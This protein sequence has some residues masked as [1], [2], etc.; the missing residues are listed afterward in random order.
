MDLGEKEDV[1]KDICWANTPP[2]PIPGMYYI[3][4]QIR[5]DFTTFDG[6]LEKMMP[7]RVYT[8]LFDAL[9][10]DFMRIVMESEEGGKEMGEGTRRSDRECEESVG[11]QERR[12]EL[13]RR[14]RVKRDMSSI[15]DYQRYI[16]E[17]F[18]DVE[19]IAHPSNKDAK[20]EAVFDLFPDTSVSHVLVQ[21]ECSGMEAGMDLEIS[22]DRGS[23]LF[24]RI[25]MPN[26]DVAVCLPQRIENFMSFQIR[27]GNAYY[28]DVGILYRL[29]E[30]RRPERSGA[31]EE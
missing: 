16:Q 26:G 3:E 9:E 25:R 7:R 2:P 23:R 22:E 4:P 5:R 10:I 20:V 21:G 13:L 8:D 1:E 15:F 28:S 19:D 17:S 24:N 27:E 6:S 11:Q 18:E 14:E 29:Q 12:G 30:Q 31:K